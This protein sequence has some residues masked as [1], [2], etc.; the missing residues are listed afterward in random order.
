[1][2][3]RNHLLKKVR[4]VAMIA[5]LLFQSIM[6]GADTI[7]TELLNILSEK[8]RVFNNIGYRIS[9]VIATNN[10]QF[11]DPSQG[12]V[13]MDCTITRTEEGCAMKITNHYEHPPVFA[14]RSK[15][16][17]GSHHDYR[18]FDYNADGNLIV[19]RTLGKHILSTPDRNDTL[20]KVRVFFVATNGEIVETDDNI[21]LHRW[22]IGSL[23]SM[24]EFRQFRLAAGRGFSK[25]LRSVT[26]VKTLASGLLEV[27]VQASRGQGLQG[28]WELT[29]DPTSDYLVRKA[30][31]TKKLHRA[32]SL[33]RMGL[34]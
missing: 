30:A 21:K 3:N 17:D 13:F 9:F 32:V 1:V 29:T 26:S 14:V 19:W 20:E 22:S 12:M 34:R 16:G 10:N 6:L 5:I 18:A 31:F 8:D 4:T 28:T 11:H 7:G 23:D 24:Y 15:P 27:T 2:V 25:D 33:K